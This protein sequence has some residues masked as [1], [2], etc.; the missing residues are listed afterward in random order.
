MSVLHEVLQLQHIILQSCCFRSYVQRLHQDNVTPQQGVTPKSGGG[1][2]SQKTT[3]KAWGES[4][5]PCSV[6]AAQ[7]LARDGASTNRCCQHLGSSALHREQAKLQCS[8]K[9]LI[10]LLA[11][12]EGYF[13]RSHRYSM[14]CI[15]SRAGAGQNQPV[16][17]EPTQR[18]QGTWG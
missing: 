1:A 11:H 4:L 8:A 5:Y 16:L 3:G 10:L 6:W 7:D 17:Q 12:P 14:G 18:G 13:F 9:C 15:S 2:H